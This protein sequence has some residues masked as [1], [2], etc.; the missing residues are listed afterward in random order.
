MIIFRDLDFNSFNQPLSLTSPVSLGVVKTSIW[1]EGA[2]R[3][4][5]INSGPEKRGWFHAKT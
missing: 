2:N 1:A 3:P 4:K 5:A